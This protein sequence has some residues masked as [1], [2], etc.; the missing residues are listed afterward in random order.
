M[1][2]SD[3]LSSAAQNGYTALIKG[4]LQGHLE[5]VKQLLEAGADKEKK[6]KVRPWDCEHGGGRVGVARRARPAC[7]AA[8]EAAAALGGRGGFGGAGSGGG[9][10]F[11]AV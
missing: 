3:P 2:P 7:A 9:S 10:A 4:A 1:R 8:A 5:V 6:S 11:Q